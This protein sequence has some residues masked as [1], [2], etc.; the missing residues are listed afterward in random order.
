MQHQ[1][2]SR[3]VDQ[4]V[5]EGMYCITFRRQLKPL[6]NSIVGVLC[7]LFGIAAHNGKLLLTELRGTDDSCRI[8]ILCMLEEAGHRAPGTGMTGASLGGNIA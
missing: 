5:V 2:L 3:Q 8:I 7:T 6:S 1:H 4:Q